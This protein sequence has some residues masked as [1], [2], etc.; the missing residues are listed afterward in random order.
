MRH[1]RRRDP[2]RS[3]GRAMDDVFDVDDLNRHQPSGN[4]K[5]PSEPDPFTGT[6]M[7]RRSRSECAAPIGRPD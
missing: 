3:E 7:A 1:S 5:G 2:V 4:P 6:S